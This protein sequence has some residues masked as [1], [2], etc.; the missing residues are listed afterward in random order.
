MHHKYHEVT[1]V[2]GLLSNQEEANTK[3]ILHSA[4]AILW[5]S[6]GDIDIMII[7]ISLTDTS[8][9]VLVITKMAKIGKVHGLTQST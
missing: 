1:T 6:S 4:H 5:S 9:R 2:D 8:K 3:G 7:A